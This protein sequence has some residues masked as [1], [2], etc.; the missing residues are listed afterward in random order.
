M[1]I[2]GLDRCLALLVSARSIFAVL[3][4]CCSLLKVLRFHW[5]LAMLLLHMTHLWDRTGGINPVSSEQRTRKYTL[6]SC[7]WYFFQPG[8]MTPNVYPWK[9]QYSTDIRILTILNCV[10]WLLSCVWLFATLWTVV[11]QAPLSL[12][13]SRQNYWSG[14]PFPSA[15]DVLN[16]GIKPESSVSPALASG[17]S[18]TD[19]PGTLYLFCVWYNILFK[20]IIVFHLMSLRNVFFNF[21]LK[22][23]S[24]DSEVITEKKKKKKK[25]AKENLSW[26]IELHPISWQYALQKEQKTKR[27][28]W[29]K[30]NFLS[31]FW[32]GRWLS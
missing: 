13:F 17:F 9:G 1:Y 30:K 12:E 14:L 11:C 31:W 22:K 20:L 15:R 8:A 6:L 24:F 3:C 2:K 29:P 23:T 16:P 21:Y 28:W 25:E 7:E 32:K 19:P 10:T 4:F 26:I 5:A 18:T 27:R